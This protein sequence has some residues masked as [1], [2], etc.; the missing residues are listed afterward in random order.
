MA[1]PT[2][3]APRLTAALDDVLRTLKSGMPLASGD[4]DALLAFLNRWAT[5]KA[6][7]SAKANIV[8][9]ELASRGIP[10]TEIDEAE[11]NKPGA[12]HAR[13]RGPRPKKSAGSLPGTDVDAFAKKLGLK[14]GAVHARI[15]RAGEA[16]WWGSFKFD[17]VTEE[18]I[19][20]PFEQRKQGEYRILDEAG[21][22]AAKSKPGPKPKGAIESSSPEN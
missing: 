11:G 7:L 21:Y 12:A 19:Q 14:A 5:V 16:D 9:E 10:L 20:L 3:S 2:G 22:H 6:E 13:L 8:A 1:Q 18:V 15:R 4:T 17:S